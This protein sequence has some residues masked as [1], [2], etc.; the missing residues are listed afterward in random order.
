[1]DCQMPSPSTPLTPPHSAASFGAGSDHSVFAH[2]YIGG[3]GSSYGGPSPTTPIHSTPPTPNPWST[4][5]LPPNPTT[6]P[7][8]PPRIR[9]R[10]S[11]QEL[12]SPRTRYA[13][14]L[15]SSSRDDSSPPPLPP[16]SA[17]TSTLP[18]NYCHSGGHVLQRLNSEGLTRRNSALDLPLAPPP[19]PRRYSQTGLSGQQTQTI[20][21][22]QSHPSSGI[23][24]SVSGPQLPPKTYRQM[25]NNAAR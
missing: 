23:P 14:P 25:L 6:P 9:A 4:A 10:K 1:M 24:L 13:P 19:T 21:S 11:S 22:P 18:R 2:V 7:P 3:G 16:R 5:S 12:T 20:S 17:A 15:M 8:L